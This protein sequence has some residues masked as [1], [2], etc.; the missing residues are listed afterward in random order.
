MQLWLHVV[1]VRGVLWPSGTEDAI[2]VYAEA[3]TQE[4]ADELALALAK[5]IYEEAAG[6]G[7]LQTTI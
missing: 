3:R 5:A 2:R 7:G 4:K 1:R 6:V